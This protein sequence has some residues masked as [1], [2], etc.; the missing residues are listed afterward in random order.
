MSARASASDPA[1]VPNA[2]IAPVFSPLRVYVVGNRSTVLALAV[3]FL[4][5]VPVLIDAVR[6][7]RYLDCSRALTFTQWMLTRY[8][9]ASLTPV[10]RGCEGGLNVDDVSETILNMYVRDPFHVVGDAH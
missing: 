3:G 7:V 1:L 8:Y 2:D 5:M 9:L 6:V 10:F 4:S